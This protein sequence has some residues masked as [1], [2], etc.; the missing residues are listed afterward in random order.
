VVHID[1]EDHRSSFVIVIVKTEEE[2]SGFGT[3]SCC[4]QAH[5]TIIDAQLHRFRIVDRRVMMDE[6]LRSWGCY[7]P[8]PEQQALGYHDLMPRGLG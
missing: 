7:I 2:Q 1:D 3:R 5:L 8:H 6:Q 4:R